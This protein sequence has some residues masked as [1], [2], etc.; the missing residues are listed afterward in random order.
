MYRFKVVQKN[1]V[2]FDQKNH[3][4]VEINGR[5]LMPLSLIDSP[6]EAQFYFEFVD[7]SG[8]VRGT[9]N[10]T[11]EDIKSTFVAAISAEPNNP[12]PAELAT[13]QSQTDIVIRTLTTGTRAERYAA[14]GMLATSYGYQLLPLE[15]QL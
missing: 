10:A 13:A 7:S 14:G 11:Q 4:I 1:I 5:V 3:T 9:K 12:T 2:D 8:T 6:I 15:E